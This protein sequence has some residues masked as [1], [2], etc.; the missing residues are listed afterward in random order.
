MVTTNGKEEEPNNHW[1]S[2]KSRLKT[3]LIKTPQTRQEERLWFPIH[4]LLMTW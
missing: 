1:F 2:T 4:Q 3:N